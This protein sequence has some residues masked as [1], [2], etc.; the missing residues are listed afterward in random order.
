MRFSNRLLPLIA[1][2]LL[3]VSCI[4]Y[5]QTMPQDTAGEPVPVLGLTPDGAH[6]IS[7]SGTSARNSTAFTSSVVMLYATQPV[8]I[9]FGGD[10]ATA[11]SSDHYFPAG[12]WHP[13]STRGYTHIAAIQVSTGGTLYVSEMR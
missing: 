7:T 5:A 13:L 3:C 4:A 11:D 1:A 10:S 8:Y 12:I 6:A 9:T 2:A